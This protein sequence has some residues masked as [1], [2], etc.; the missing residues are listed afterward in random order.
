MDDSDSNTNTSLGTK[1][2]YSASEWQALRED[3]LA[4][5]KRMLGFI[6]ASPTPFHAVGRIT[7]QLDED[8]FRPLFERNAWRLEPGD[9][10]YVVRDDSTLVAFVV[11]SEA[12]ATAGFRIIGAH[13]DSPNLR[14]K[15]KAERSKRGYLQ[16]GVEIYG[17]VLLATW[18]DRDLSIAGRVLCREG[19]GVMA[20]MVDLRRP[21]AR[22]SNL[23]IHLNRNVNKDGLHLNKQRHMVPMVGLGDKLDLRAELAHS[24]GVASDDIISYDLSLYDVQHGAIG[25][26]NDEFVYSARLDNLG[27]CFTATEALCGA[28]GQNKS[29]AVMVLYDHE[30]VGS[31]SA[32]GAAS[33]ILQDVLYRIAVAYPEGHVQAMPRAIANSIL[34]SAD[35]AHALH[36]NYSEKHDGDHAPALNRGLVIKSNVNQSYATTGATAAEFTQLCHNAGFEPQQFVVRSDLPCGSTIGP[37]TASRLGIRT[38]DVGAPMLSM[39]SCR[40]MAGTLDVHLAVKAYQGLFT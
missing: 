18:A 15:P 17:G 31:R 28:S 24:A 34:L 30:E 5:A 13:T 3:G 32:I 20:R 21:V 14:V 1:F 8:G 11:G 7:R 4:A 29:T 26:L 37:I 27:S 35:M 16:L 25:G 36:P 39:H 10:R 40:E 19:N 2:A 23:A 38:V 6:D 9:R 22:V 12:P 33:S